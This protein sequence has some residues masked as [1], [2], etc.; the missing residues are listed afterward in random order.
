MN[1]TLLGG[2]L[3]A[4]SVLLAYATVFRWRT[5]SRSM[6]GRGSLRWGR[7][8]WSFPATR[9]GSFAGVAWLLFIGSILLL[10]PGHSGPGAYSLYCVSALFAYT[11]FAVV[12]DL[13][14]YRR[15][16]TRTGQIHQIDTC[17]ICGHTAEEHRAGRC[18]GGIF[19]VCARFVSEPNQDG[20]ATRRRT[21][22]A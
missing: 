19:C 5:F 21:P 16:R 12:H 11:L 1:K 6:L 9:V 3:V 18:S 20:H 2:G 7:G 14:H 10:T 15:R 4:L 8:F 22:R 17:A 13:I